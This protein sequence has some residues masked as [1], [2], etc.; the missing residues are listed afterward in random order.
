MIFKA[1]KKWN[2]DLKRSYIVGDRYKDILA[3]LN[4]GLK[5]IY[6]FN[7]YKKDKT[8]VFYHYKINSLKQVLRKVRYD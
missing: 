1:K 5:T 6:L 4:A 2:I 8:P 7:G 3:G